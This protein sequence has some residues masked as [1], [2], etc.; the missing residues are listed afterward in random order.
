MKNEAFSLDIDSYLSKTYDRL[1]SEMGIR[2]ISSC[3]F[4]LSF[5]SSNF[6]SF[7]SAM[8]C[9][10]IF[11]KNEDKERGKRAKAQ[12]KEAQGII[13]RSKI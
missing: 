5:N 12:N 3:S 7:A 4:N 2:D 11:G 6:R 9:L 10:G 8:A 13:I 1:A